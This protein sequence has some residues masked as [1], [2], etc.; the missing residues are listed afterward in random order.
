MKKFCFVLLFSALLFGALYNIAAQST[1]PPQQV[2]NTSAFYLAATAEQAGL[3]SDVSGFQQLVSQAFSV[4]FP[5]SSVAVLSRSG[6]HQQTISDYLSLLILGL[7]LI[8]FT[9]PQFTH[10][11]LRQE[12]HL[13]NVGTLEGEDEDDEDS[14]AL[15]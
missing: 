12:T 1:A 10:R 3:E 4:P 9:G 8:V 11:Q 14:F 15:A 6:V 5:E 7:L 13:R 2:E